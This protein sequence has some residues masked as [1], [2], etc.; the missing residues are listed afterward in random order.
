M[1][2]VEHLTYQ[3][4]DESRPAVEDLSLEIQDGDFVAILGNNGSGKSTLA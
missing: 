4:P 3:Y 2:R 1:I